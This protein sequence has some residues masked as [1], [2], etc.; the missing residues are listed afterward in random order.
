MTILKEKPSHTGEPQDIYVKKRQV[1]H[2][3]L[4]SAALINLMSS[5]DC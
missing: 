5:D 3:V 2:F 1:Q 4:Q